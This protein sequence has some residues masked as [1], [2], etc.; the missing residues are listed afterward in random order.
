[1]ANKK[2]VHHACMHGCMDASFLD[3]IDAAAHRL[4]VV[5][6][7]SI[8]LSHDQG[9]YFIFFPNIGFGTTSIKLAS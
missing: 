4:I 3:L 7:S 9:Y 2:L 5:W 1:M 8:N 6:G